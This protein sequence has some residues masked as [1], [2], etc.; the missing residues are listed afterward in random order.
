MTDE[1]LDM[2]RVDEAQRRLGY[3]DKDCLQNPLSLACKAL[4]VAREAWTPSDIDQLEARAIMHL[5]YQDEP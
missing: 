1:E 4:E 2:A 3:S 5:R